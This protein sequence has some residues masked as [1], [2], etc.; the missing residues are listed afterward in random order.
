MLQLLLLGL[1]L[2]HAANS[3]EFKIVIDIISI[4]DLVLHHISHVGVTFEVIVHLVGVV[5]AKAAWLVLPRLQI[6]LSIPELVLNAHLTQSQQNSANALAVAGFE[7][8]RRHIEINPQLLH[9]KDD[10]LR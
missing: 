7:L 10:I 5:V 3:S 8:I 4:A 6:V 1:G 9:L 2:F